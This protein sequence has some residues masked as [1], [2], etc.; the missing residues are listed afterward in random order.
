MPASRS[1]SLK[2]VLGNDCARFDAGG[3][4]S[5]VDAIGYALSTTCTAVACVF[6]LPTPCVE[7]S[8]IRAQLPLQHIPYVPSK[9]IHD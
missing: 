7:R 8:R 4:N 6:N 1:A 2:P 9:S 5:V 3:Y